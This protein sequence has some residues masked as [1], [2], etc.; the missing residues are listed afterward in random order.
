MIKHIVFFR[1]QPEANG[2]SAAE[3]AEALVAML[4][5]LPFTIP[6]IV[7]LEVGN[8]F[9]RTAA[10]WDI[11]LYSEFR[12]R[13]DLAVYQSHPEHVRVKDFVGVTTSERAVVDY[14]V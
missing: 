10:A 3:N 2:G 1:M 12:T 13:E 4:R 5:A 11:A 7:S 6:E 8:N 9:C 14:E